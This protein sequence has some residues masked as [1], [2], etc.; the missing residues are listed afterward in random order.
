MGFQAAL[1]MVAKEFPSVCG[2]CGS[3]S[4]PAPSSPMPTLPSPSPPSPLLPPSPSPPSP[5]PVLPSTRF[6]SFGAA[7]NGL[8][9]GNMYGGGDGRY[10]DCICNADASGQ[11][12]V[13]AAEA[14]SGQVTF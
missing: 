12:A 2:A 7:C 6:V 8:G 13:T 1:Q 14:I 3:S 5:P 4:S 9:V 10:E 11:R